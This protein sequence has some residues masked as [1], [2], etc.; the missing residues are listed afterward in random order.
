M[1]KGRRYDDEP[2]LNMKKV[3]AVIV[4][5]VVI[6]M[7]IFVIKGALSKGNSKGKISSESYYTIYENEKYGVIN[8]NG[9]IIVDPAYKEL[10]IIPNSKNDVFICTYDVD[11]SS[12]TY[13]TKALDSKN[14]EIF[15]E[16]SKVEAIQ[17]NDK[18]N[19][20]WYE[21]SVL[22]VQKDGKYGLI[23]LTGKV[24]L[25]MQYDEIEAL[26]GIKNSLIIKKDGKLGIVDKDG[27]IIVEPKYLDITNLG[28]DNKSGFI[29][30]DTNEKY[31][32]IDYSSNVVLESKYDSIEKVSGSSLYVVK[33]AGKTKVVKQNGTDYITDGFDTIKEILKNSSNGVIFAKDGKYGVMKENNQIVIEPTYEDLSQA[34]D[35]TLI[36]KKNGKYGVIDFSANQKILFD[37]KSIKYDEIAD[38]FIT[39]NDS[40]INTVINSVYESKLSGILVKMDTEKGYM[41]LRV[42]E[43]YKYYNFKFEEKAVTDILVSNTLFLSKKDGKYGFVDKNGKVVVDYIYDDAT[44][45]NS[46][47]FCAV[48]KDGKWGSI[49]IKG[50]VCQ[51]PKYNLD[52]YL[53]IDF[54]GKWHL[55]KDIN[56]NCY[57]QE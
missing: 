49:D 46:S 15:T 51:E 47:G 21:D 33:E 25:D 14:E 5:I 45:Q 2:K 1:N 53:E 28:K 54:V 43:D 27:K 22:K 11:Y 18:N 32:V 44:D 6:L 17:N 10:I 4:A 42:G 9:D 16:Y 48:K 3:F 12:G 38:I 40:L 30:K 55:G 24:L 39:E 7:S 37:Y 8:S 56:M 31:G 26:E 36:A 29:I 41:K 57:N 50:N 23:N 20:I 52:D 13:K 19:N 35:T 34:Q